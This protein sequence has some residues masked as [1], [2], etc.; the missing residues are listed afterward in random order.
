MSAM[1]SLRGVTKRYE[2]NRG[3]VLSLDTVD[4]DVDEGEFVT[5]VGPSGCGKST[6]LNLIAGLLAPTTGTVT[7]N[8]AQVRGPGRSAA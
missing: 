4:V 7:V 8:G 5:L 2:T 1:I 3:S 6:M